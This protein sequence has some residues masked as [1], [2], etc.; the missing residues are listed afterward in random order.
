MHIHHLM[1]EKE[2][3]DAFWRE[4]ERINE[5][6]DPRQM[7]ITVHMNEWAG[8]SITE[9]TSQVPRENNNGERINRMCSSISLHVAFTYFQNME[10]QNIDGIIIEMK[11]QKRVWLIPFTMKIMIICMIHD[12]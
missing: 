11:K 1:T 4:P 3:K 12:L 7:I 2:V 6:L 9:V 8:G 5:R 10:F